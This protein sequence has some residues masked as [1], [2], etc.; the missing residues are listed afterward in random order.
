MTHATKKA[1]ADALWPGETALWGLAG[2]GVAQQGILG[3]DVGTTSVKAGLIGEGGAFLATASHAYATTRPRPGWAEQNADDWLA[4]VQR[5]L[6]QVCAGRGPAGIV[7]L[8]LTSQVNTHVFVDASGRALMPAMTWQDGRAAP[9]AAELDAQVTPA[10]KAAWWGAPMPID[11]SHPLPRMLWVK[12]HR[13]EVWAETALVLL[14]KDYCLL[15]LTGVTATDPLSNFGIV[16]GKGAYIGGLLDLVPGA[17]QRLAPLI[18]PTQTIGT[19][20]AGDPLAGRPVACGTMDAWAGLVGCGGVRQGAQVYLSGTS[21]ILGVSSRGVSPTP[22]VVVFPEHGGIR[23]HAAPTQSGGEAALWFA[24]ISGH[25]VGALSDMVAAAPRSPA[26]PLFLPQLEGERAP[27][28]DASLR[29]AFL[30]LS[31]STTT[32][33]MARAVFEGVALSARHALGP[34]RASAQVGTDVILCGGGGFRSGAWT[35]IRA[36]V[37][38]CALRPIAAAEPGVLGAGLMALV[39]VGHHASLDAA[40]S[41]TARLGPLVEPD[42]RSAARYDTLFAL[43]SDAITTADTLTKRLAQ[44]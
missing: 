24:G 9:E 44:I 1:L 17:Q 18:P 37:L 4:L 22:G 36:N 32:T 6:A 5:C 25:T 43:Y 16:D 42:S 27:L 8:G 19:V 11:A 26:T 2:D 41:A 34:L 15:H 20:R 23:L 3:V 7:G 13:P 14:P 10:Q 33:D 31:R 35:Q 30:G 28:W 21:E 40:W 29:A 38:G 39:A 12:R